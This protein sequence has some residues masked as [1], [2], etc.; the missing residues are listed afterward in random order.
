MSFALQPGRAAGAAFPITPEE[1]RVRVDLAAA[2]RL[3]AL[4]RWDDLIYT[5]IS[6]T[7]PGEPDHFLINPFGFAFEEIRASDLVKINSRGEVV[8]EV[9][10]P[11]N[12]TGFALHAAVHAVRTDAHCVMHLH[13][14]AGISVS[15]Q[16]EGLLP[17]SQH[18][19]R[20]HGRIAYHDY[21]GLAFTP[22]EGARLTASL[23][24]HPAMLLRN[25]GTL[26][27]GRTVAEA[28]VLMATLIKACEIQ[29]GAQLGSATVQPPR[30][31]A[32][33]TSL[34]LYDNGAVEGVMEWPSLLRKLDR[35]D[36]SYKN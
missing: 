17:L 10:H 27:V 31:I 36:P 4:E 1:A 25:H 28:Y 7:V 24:A 3:A 13:N 30:D 5:H 18:A 33:R 22:A 8:G 21:E 34:Q 35:I 11:V 15:A 9:V 26:T 29:L 32:D 23:G 6:A 14:T 20:F 19:M 2:Y 16:A 12:V